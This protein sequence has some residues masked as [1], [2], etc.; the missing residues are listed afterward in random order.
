MS[1]FDAQKENFAFLKVAAKQPEN[2]MI[3]FL[4]VVNRGRFLGNLHK[5][6]HR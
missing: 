5:N 6:R 3:L 1:V 2:Q 4:R